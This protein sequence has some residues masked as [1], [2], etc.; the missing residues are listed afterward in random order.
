[1]VELLNQDFKSSNI[2]AVVFDWDGTLYN[3]VPAI[4]AATRDVLRQFEIEYPVDLA[5]EEFLDLMENINANSI[6]KILLNSYQ[7][8]SDV[9]FIKDLSYSHKLE[10]L[11]L[12]Y[13]KYKQYSK[14][15]TLFHGTEELLKTLST[16]VDLAIYTSSKKQVILDLLEKFGIK[17]YFKFIYTV[18]D[19]SNQKPHPEGILKTL[20]DLGV[21]SHEAV[22]IGDLKTDLK[23]AKNA[24]VNSFAVYNGLIRRYKLQA[25]KPDLICDHVSELSSVFN[26]PEISVDR[27]AE[28]EEMKREIQEV[29]PLF[30]KRLTLVRLIGEVV[31]IQIET[32]HA[33]KIMM[34]P[35][36]FIGAVIKD[37]VTRYTHEDVDLSSE[38]EVFSGAEEDLL[39]SFGLILIHFVNERSNN[40]ISRIR[41]NALLGPVF[42]ILISFLKVSRG[43]WYPEELDEEFKQVFLKAIEKITPE[44]LYTNLEKMDFKSFSDCVFEGVE[45]ALID[46]GYERA[47]TTKLPFSGAALTPLQFISKTMSM[48]YREFNDRFM[49]MTRDML[50]RDFRHLPSRR[51]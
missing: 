48:L 6:T 13:S 3:N 27:E 32:E 42:N 14:D 1:M 37:I 46:L 29:K 31:P 49:R 15:S 40:L 7:I 24:S 22:Y 5:V 19:V 8:L 18:D 44:S 35:M 39:R 11:F 23:A 25:E 34:D 17:H 9:L 28:L 33:K 26:L 12:I 16:K 21:D 30:K 41:E 36:G 45:H 2:K 50:E 4:K 38:L 10:L 47:L 51:H 43:N 20:S